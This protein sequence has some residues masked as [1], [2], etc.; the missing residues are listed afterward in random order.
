MIRRNLS[1]NIAAFC[2]IMGKLLNYRI[3]IPC[4]ESGIEN[5]KKKTGD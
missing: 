3:N 1:K 4:R 2:S 5:N